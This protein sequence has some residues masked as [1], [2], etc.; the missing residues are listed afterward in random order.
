M[1]VFQPRSVGV[2]P[3]FL[4]V[5]VS[6]AFELEIKFLLQCFESQ[7]AGKTKVLTFLTPYK[8]RPGVS[9]RRLCN[10]AVLLKLQKS[11]EVLFIFGLQGQVM[12]LQV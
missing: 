6:S 2:M 5:N 8:H 12:T 10:D 11:R 4:L 1:T 3:W 7:N 9:G